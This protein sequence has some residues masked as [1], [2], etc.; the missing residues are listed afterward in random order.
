MEDESGKDVQ[1]WNYLSSVTIQ[2]TVTIQYYK[3]CVCECQT[4]FY[5]FP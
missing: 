5:K 3:Y 2:E 4:G 1:V